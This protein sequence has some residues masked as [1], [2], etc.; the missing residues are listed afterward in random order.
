MALS[1]VHTAY[2]VLQ[3]IP[4]WFR[5]GQVEGR[6]LYVDFSQKAIPAESIIVPHRQVDG[7]LVKL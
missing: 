2:P 5:L 3:S 1:T 7:A 4:L 6:E